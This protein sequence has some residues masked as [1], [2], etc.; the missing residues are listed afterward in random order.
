MQDL[1]TLIE[2]S[3]QD[4]CL[5]KEELS[6]IKKYR[7][8]KIESDVLKNTIVYYRLFLNN[9]I[10]TEEF[11]DLFKWG[12]ILNLDLMAEFLLHLNYVKYPLGSYK[13]IE[14]DKKNIGTYYEN[15]EKD[16]KDTLS[17]FLFIKKFMHSFVHFIR[18]NYVS[19][20]FCSNN[21]KEENNNFNLTNQIIHRTSEISRNI[22]R[23]NHISYQKDLDTLEKL[24]AKIKEEELIKEDSLSNLIDGFDFQIACINQYDLLKQELDNILSLFT[25]LK[26]KKEVSL[27]EKE[28]YQTF[29]F[30]LKKFI[31]KRQEELLNCYKMKSNN[32]EITYTKI[33]H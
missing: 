4:E 26:P 5:H 10:T 22:L 31:E 9:Q 29:A 14:K 7:L 18:Q 16:I 8:E 3:Y 25:L 33:K 27:Y 32:E 1:L 23:I 6:I 17:R 24:L 2:K 28:F 13:Y 19:S 21:M 11:F 12:N 20:F 15:K 30:S